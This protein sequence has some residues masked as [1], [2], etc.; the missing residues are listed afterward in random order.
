MSVKQINN[1]PELR[2]NAGI[3]RI[4]NYKNT[5]VVPAGTQNIAR[6][7]QKYGPNTGF[8]VINN[9]LF[10]QLNPTTNLQVCRPTERDQVLQAIYDDEEKGLGLGLGQFFRQVSSAFLNIH[11]Y[12]TDEFLSSQG[13]YQLTKPTFKHIN[14]PIRSRGVN[15]IWSIDL[16]DM[17]A[18]SG[19]INNNRKYIFSCVDLYSGKVWARAISSRNN[20]AN[21]HVLR[22]AFES[23]CTEATVRPRIVKS[24]SEF[25]EGDI[26]DW[27]RQHNI[28]VIK[29]RSHVPTDNAVVER[30][31]REIR[32]KIKAGFIRHNNV[33][34]VAHLQ[35]YV[36]NINNQKKLGEEYTPEDKWANGFNAPMA[37]MA[38]AGQIA[39]N[40][41]QIRTNFRVRDIVRIKLYTVNNKT[42]A[43]EKN[44]IESKKNV[45]NFTPEVYK[46]FRTY[47][48]GQNKKYAVKKINIPNIQPTATGQ[49]EIIFA[50]DGI[51]YMKF[52]GSDLQ[53]VG[54]RTIADVI[55]TSLNPQT[56]ASALRRINKIRGPIEVI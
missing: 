37:P 39:Q 4:I 29:S 21:R 51:H 31:N 28:K 26:M 46:V 48:V 50:P 22:T 49:D 44:G 35:T 25:A 19:P 11:K 5:N 3:N 52:Y 32:K 12:H 41:I 56:N 40:R 24:D 20:K 1:Y 33:A 6:Y 30:Y 42:R 2:T 16:I 47:G 27:F 45:V 23:I 54:T 36:K 43:R 38:P 53:S 10:F 18:Y 8:N 13:D 7:V 34:W 9:D 55:H 14:K 17:K 15:Q